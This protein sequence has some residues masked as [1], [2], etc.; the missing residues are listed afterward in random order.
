MTARPLPAVGGTGRET[1]VALAADLLV[2]VVLGGQ[3]LER[4]LDDTATETVSKEI[5]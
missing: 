2:A 3:D 4:G 5:S 1:S